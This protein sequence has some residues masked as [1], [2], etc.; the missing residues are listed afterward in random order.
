MSVIRILFITFIMM[1]HQVT[2]QN[3]VLKNT[4]KG[5]IFYMNGAY[6]DAVT[7][8]EKAIEAAPFDFKSTY[9]L[10][11]AFFKLKKYDKALE[12]Y[13]S[14]IDRGETRIDNAM[15]HHNI[16]NCYMMKS[17]FKA[18]IDAY[19]TSLRLNPFDEATRYNLAYAML[20]QKEKEQQQEKNNQNKNQDQDQ[21]DQK[22][23]NENKE[24]QDNKD[25][26]DNQQD[27]SDKNNEDGDQKD[28]NQEN[29]NQKDSDGDQNKEEKDE[30]GQPKPQPNKLSKEQAKRILEA[31]AKQEK[32]IQD[33]KDQKIKIGTGKPQ[34]KKD[35]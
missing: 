25:N 20:K 16:G 3:T 33:K 7:S 10:G 15:I 6:K 9:N 8:Y 21:K 1:S 17:E 29:N 31:A 11:N 26:K 30:S 23:Q 4:H 32:E 13:E 19:K 5:N 24:N 28:K 27:K 12:K 34:A 2:A 22:D 35:W 14:V 18:A